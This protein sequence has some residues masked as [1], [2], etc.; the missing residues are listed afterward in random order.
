MKKLSIFLC[1]LCLLMVFGLTACGSTKAK[2]YGIH[3]CVG[4]PENG[5]VFSYA[6]AD[7]NTLFE[8]DY[9]LEC[10][11]TYHLLVA[12]S[13]GGGSQYPV[14][15]ANTIK[16]YYDD[17][18]LEINQPF[19]SIGEVICYQLTCRESIAYTAVIVEVDGEYSSTVIISAK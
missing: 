3:S 16:L 1:S 7:E 19:E 17:N 2:I 5:N 13:A 8:N 14:M 12:Y 15:S 10:G 4:L 9:V 6:L 18:A 11:Q